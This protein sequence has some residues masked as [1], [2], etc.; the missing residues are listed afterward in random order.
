MAI[1]LQLP[2]AVETCLTTERGSLPRWAVEAIAAEGY[3]QEV[4]T[5][6]QVGEMLDLNFWETES[7]LKGWGA[8]LHYTEGDLDRDRATNQR[9]L[10]MKQ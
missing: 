7:F 10:S 4:F 8:S 5:R 1:T 9:V 3:R 2:K 6:G